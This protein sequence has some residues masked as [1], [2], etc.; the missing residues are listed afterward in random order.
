[1]ELRLSYT[2][3]SICYDKKSA[4]FGMKN[5]TMQRFNLSTTDLGI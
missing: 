5:E 1:M 2:N 3:P 4:Y